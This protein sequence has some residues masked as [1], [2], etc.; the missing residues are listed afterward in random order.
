MSIKDVIL[1]TKEQLIDLIELRF[2]R[3][4]KRL[5]TVDFTRIKERLLKNEQAIL[6]LIYMEQT[7][8]EPALWHYDNEKD[9]YV[10]VDLSKES[11]E[12]RSICY[13]KEAR[14]SRKKFP[15][16]TSA[17]ELVEKHN[18]QILDETMYYELQK[19]GPFDTKT[20]S[21]I[22]TPNSIRD[23]KGALFCDYHYGRVFTYCNG[24]DSYYGSRG[25]RAFIEV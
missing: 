17:I 21:W 11:P 4:E 15:P 1:M 3:D 9:V 18:L 25:F 10:F 16:E 14:I 24:A 2:K 12:R 6:S 13:D 23:Q 8:G 20:S 19:L 5:E 22:L 7:K